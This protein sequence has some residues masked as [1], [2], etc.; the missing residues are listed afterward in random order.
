MLCKR[1]LLP[2]ICGLPELVLDGN[3]LLLK[4][5]VLLSYLCL[6]LCRQLSLGGLFGSCY[7]RLLLQ[8]GHLL[9]EPFRFLLQ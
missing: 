9:F 6:R 8:C 1:L 5:L 3:G 4:C 7:G 2:R